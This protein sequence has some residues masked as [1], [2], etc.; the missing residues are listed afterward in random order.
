VVEVV[1]GRIPLVGGLLAAGAGLYFMMA[2][3]RLAGIFYRDQLG[4]EEA[5]END[6][7]L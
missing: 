1:L 4:L 5:D 2:Q 7:V 6:G 3:A